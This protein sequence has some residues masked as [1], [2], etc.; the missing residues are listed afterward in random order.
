MSKKIKEKFTVD[1]DI[2]YS[3][4][5][6]NC[7]LIE[8]NKNL[9]DL[10]K[11]LNGRFR[12]IRRMLKKCILPGSYKINDWEEYHYSIESYI[13]NSLYEAENSINQIKGFLV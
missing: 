10:V 1:R 13:H 4:L 3:V 6:N 7:D 11:T 9:E 2:Y 8:K 5:K 12:G